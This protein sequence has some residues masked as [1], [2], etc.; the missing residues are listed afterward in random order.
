[1]IIPGD[2]ALILIFL[3]FISFAIIS[4][5]LTNDILDIEY[6]TKVFL[7]LVVPPPEKT[8]SNKSFFNLIY[9]YIDLK[10]YVRKKFILKVFRIYL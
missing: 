4:T 7:K 1:M 9:G 3:L 10:K 2:I 8:I 6:E 5:S